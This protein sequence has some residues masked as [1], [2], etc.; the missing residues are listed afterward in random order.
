M[1]YADGSLAD[2]LSF[3]RFLP[4]ALAAADKV[5]LE[6]SPELYP[7]AAHQPGPHK[8]IQRGQKLPAVDYRLP[9]GS[10]LL[11]SRCRWE[12]LSGPPAYLSA[13]SASRLT[14]ACSER[15][16]MKVGIN[17]AHQENGPPNHIRRPPFAAFLA[18]TARPDITVYALQKGE[19]AVDLLD[20]GGLA[21]ARDLSPQIQTW[22]DMAAVVRQLDLVITVDGPLAHLAGALGVPCW[23]ALSRRGD[24]RW[25]HRG[26]GEPPASLWYPRTRLFDKD[27][28]LG[29]DAT[30]AA[31][32]KAL[33]D[34]RR[35]PEES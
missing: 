20:A 16:P 32:E 18:L 6:I 15:A 17:W 22:A 25:R 12:D 8:V 1:I 34:S 14:L 35:Q 23:V 7:L 11:K 2:S 21:L 31:M 27:P 30:F 28:Q 4:W 5:T 29:W 19:R 3:L 13:P 33:D 26:P 10:L 24:W 9:L